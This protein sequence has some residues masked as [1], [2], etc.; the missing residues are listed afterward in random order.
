MN[1]SK[2]ELRAAAGLQSRFKIVKI[3][4]KKTWRRGRW[5]CRD[6]SDPLAS[7]GS[8]EPVAGVYCMPATGEAWNPPFI[9]TIIY[10]DGRPGLDCGS[11]RAEGEQKVLEP[12]ASVRINGD[13]CVVCISDL[14]SD[15]LAICDEP[16]LSSID[17]KLPLKHCRLLSSDNLAAM[18]VDVRTA[19]YGNEGQPLSTVLGSALH[20]VVATPGVDQD[21]SDG[22]R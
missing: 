8:D 4:S 3:E 15:L 20:L 21:L 19:M 14:Q 10:S 6:F 22:S 1:S 16:S 18:D 7:H 11:V 12:Y 17:G 13:N 2:D 5:I 9:A